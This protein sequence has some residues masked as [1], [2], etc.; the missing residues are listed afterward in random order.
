MRWITYLARRDAAPPSFRVLPW[1]WTGDEVKSP[2]KIMKSRFR[3]F[4][5][6][7][8][9]I[10]CTFGA[11]AAASTSEQNWPGWRGPLANG[12]APLGNPPVNWSET[13][14]VKWKVKIP[15]RGSATPIV[16]G[17]QVFVQ[18]AIPTGRKIEA[19]IK[20][21]APPLTNSTG[22]DQPREGRRGGRAGGG[23]PMG[24]GKPTEVYQFALL[25]RPRDW[26]DA[27]AENRPRRTAPRGSSRRRRH[28]R[29]LVTI[30]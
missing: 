30:D 27:V 4:W 15:G 22:G 17:N 18:T 5:L 12:V 21:L 13:N 10:P 16:W 19:A 8:A 24:G 23:G 6:S 3:F 1:P 2:L 9:L 25:S 26:Q 20:Q 28:L 29:L 11:D 7:L 14:N